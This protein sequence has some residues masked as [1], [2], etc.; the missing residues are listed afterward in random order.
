VGFG[1]ASAAT[2]LLSA[3]MRAAGQNESV[4]VWGTEAQSSSAVAEHYVL[5]EGG[6]GNSSCDLRMVS[7]QDRRACSPSPWEAS[8]GTPLLGKPPHDTAEVKGASSLYAGDES[9]AYAPPVLVQTANAVSSTTLE[10]PVCR[11]VLPPQADLAIT[12][13]LRPEPLPQIEKPK[14]KKL[15]GIGR[16]DPRLSVSSHRWLMKTKPMEL[17][18]HTHTADTSM[19]MHANPHRYWSLLVTTS[20]LAAMLSFL[21][22]QTTQA[23]GDLRG[24]FCASGSTG[25]VLN[26]LVNSVVVMLA[27]LLVRTT[28]EAEGSGIPEVKTM[29]FGKKLDSFLTLRVLGVKA[30]ALATV[31]GAGLPIGKEG[32]FVHL[33]SCITA[34]LDPAF[35]TSSGA[36]SHLLLASCAVGV[37]TTFSS[38]LGGVIFALELMLPQVYDLTAYW[39]CFTAS[40]S[41]SLVYASLKMYTQG[42]TGLMPLIS[43]DVSPGEGVASTYPLLRL[44]MDIVLGAI[45]GLLGGL[46]IRMHTFTQVGLKNWRLRLKAPVRK[47]ADRCACGNIF[48]ED[49][50]FCRKCGSKRPQVQPP[51]AAAPAT[52]T[53]DNAD[54]LPRVKAAQR[55]D[56]DRFSHRGKSWA[57]EED[58]NRQSQS[59]F[60]RSSWTSWLGRFEWRDLVLV[61]VVA[62][63]NTITNEH[64]PLLAGK[65]Q[66]SLMSLLFS[67]KLDQRADEWAVLSLGAGPTIALCFL[68]KWVMTVLAL[69]LPTPTGIVA[70]TMIV[71]ALIGRCYV[72][73]IPVEFQ[74]FLLVAEGHE[75]SEDVRGAFAARFA[76]VGAAAFCAA[77]ARAFSMAITVFEVLALPNSVLPLSTASLTA[78]FVANEICP[79]FFDQIL[80]TKG[81]AG[82]PAITSQRRAMLPVSRVMRRVDCHSEC[83]SHRTNLSDMRRLLD[84]SKEQFFPVVHHL[85]GGVDALLIGTM[86]RDAIHTV[87]ER[88]KLRDSDVIDFLEPAQ[89]LQEVQS[90]SPLVNRMPLHVKPDTAVKDVFLLLKV[91]YN[92]PL[93]YV[94]S[95]GRLLGVIG[96][97]ELLGKTT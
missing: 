27:R 90:S 17:E 12:V 19:D 75:V 21:V 85:R 5:S 56:W 65:T 14:G 53:K 58:N 91:M 97:E 47:S 32:P 84:K 54:K 60:S 20:L 82:V 38:P 87:I 7:D 33:A 22:D 93:V 29:L 74:N 49:A 10:E 67:K 6:D 9:S 25:L 51:A 11:P 8:W 26:V 92:E 42:A 69:S 68:S 59:R 72:S 96:V 34:N 62:A 2:V 45:C 70:P 24:R 63:V 77:V 4:P 57:A 81:L 35:Y 50:A 40:V 41:A 23:M 30:V 55:V 31:V 37:G 44:S 15:S 94:T 52:G 73:L 88:R 1:L 3:D 61:G 78:I 28:A 18:E 64:L 76:I 16:M 95:R 80:L 13:P 79:G 39:G 71:G 48:M 89:W 86:A 43:S 66:P 36:M 83:L 46:F